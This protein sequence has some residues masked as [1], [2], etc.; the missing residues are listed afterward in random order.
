VYLSQEK[1]DEAL[2]DLNRALELNPDSVNA[3]MLRAMA[4]ARNENLQAA[5]ADVN[6]ALEIDPNLTEA[7]QQRALIL[8]AEGKF[9]EAIGDMRRL[10]RSGADDPM[11]LLQLGSLYVA[12]QQ[13]R[14]AI[15][16]FTQLLEK[17]PENARARRGRADAYL[18]IGKQAEAI[19]DYDH[20]LRID[21]QDTGT[22]NNLAWVLA[23]SPDAK[24]RDGERAI[25]LATKASELTEYQAAH[26]LSTLAAAYAESGDFAKAKEWSQKAVDLGG[27]QIEQLKLELESYQQGK[28]W[29]ELQQVEERPQTDQPSE[30]DLEPVPVPGQ[31]N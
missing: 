11:L 22:L 28:P 3:L 18:S 7:V 4:H 9:A 6:R 24:L 13:P 30:A 21:D 12:A 2:E 10:I 19:G 15:D 31:V 25:E 5:R 8:A 23:T 29:R 14:A 1:V 20:A 16:I 26:I 17:D 27:E